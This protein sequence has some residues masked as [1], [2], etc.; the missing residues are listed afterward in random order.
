MNV[1]RIDG[2]GLGESERRAGRDMMPDM[3][4]EDNGRPEIVVEPPDAGLTDEVDDRLRSELESCPDVAFAHLCQVTVAG[5]STG[6]LLSLFVWLVPEA[7][8]SLRGALNL[9]CEAVAR[10]IPEDVFI[11]VLILNSAPELLDRVE[12]A[13]CLLVERDHEERRRALEAAKGQPED[14][15]S[16]PRRRLWPW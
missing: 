8:G 13:D 11:D 2:P 6:P 16:P 7:V 15:G 10:A 4:D 5:Q 12:A 9:V 1:A 3:V 14:P